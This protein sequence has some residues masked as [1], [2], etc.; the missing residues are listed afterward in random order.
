MGLFKCDKCG[1]VEYTNHCNYFK[2]K[3]KNQ[4]LLCSECDPDIKKW[5]EGFPKKNATEEGYMLGND[6][7]LYTKWQVE[8]EALLKWKE[9]F[10]NFKIVGPA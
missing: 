4:P 6:G 10:E 7:M 2:R 1:S 8:N 5:K 3:E 9:M